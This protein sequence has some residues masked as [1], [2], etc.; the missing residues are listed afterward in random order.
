MEAGYGIL[1]I[2]GYIFGAGGLFS[3]I[4]YFK[5]NKQ[6]KI[7]EVELADVNVK[8]AAAN[9]KLTDATAETSI[10]ENYEKL[11]D[12]LESTITSQD[13]RIEKIESFHER[14][15]Q[16]L[17]KQLDI[18]TTKIKELSKKINADKPFICYDLNCK[19]RKNKR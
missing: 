10:V 16:E 7:K 19:V 8:L 4:A 5:Q 17:S 2:L 13:E 1:E 15:Y 3:L 18:N 6:L 12:R 9:V 14:R 11:I